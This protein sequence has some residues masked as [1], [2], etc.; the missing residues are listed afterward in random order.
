MGHGA[1]MLPRADP[2]RCCSSP[3]YACVSASQVIWYKL[4][5]AKSSSP[6]GV[7][8]V[9]NFGSALGIPCYAHL[10]AGRLLFWHIQH[11]S[12]YNFTP[13]HMSKPWSFHDSTRYR[14]MPRQHSNS[15][16]TTAEARTSSS[17]QPASVVSRAEVTRAGPAQ[18][19]P[20]ATASA[21]PRSRHQAGLG[22]ARST[23]ASSHAST[24]AHG[25]LRAGIAAAVQGLAASP[26]QQ[27]EDPVS[28]CPTEFVRIKSSAGTAT[29]DSALPMHLFADRMEVYFVHR[30][31]GQEVHLVIY[32]RDVVH[33]ACDPDLLRGGL[34]TLRVQLRGQLQHLRR[35][36]DVAGGVCTCEVAVGLA[37]KV[38]ERIIMD[39]LA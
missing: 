1:W 35:W 36:C 9:L 5:C 27:A 31:S 26:A 30:R 2:S 17:Q 25:R 4:W 6:E 20:R 14:A 3:L 8:A 11:A 32:K 15:T 29:S 13:S 18:P 24:Q 39:H 23:R 22:Q 16:S 33:A 37:A 38:H 12:T 19:T 10:L 21:R 7:F 28:T 34:P